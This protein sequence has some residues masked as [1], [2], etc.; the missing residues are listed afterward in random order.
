M[1]NS[2]RPHGLQP[3]RLLCPWGF[4][5]QD[6]QSE[7]RFP[8]PG[9]SP[10]PQGSN[11]GIPHCGQILYSLSH[12][13]RP[14][15]IVETPHLETDSPPP[16]SRFSRVRLCAT[17]RTA[18]Y[19]ASLSMGFSRQ[20][21]WSGL[22]FPSPETDSS[23][24]QCPCFPSPP[25]IPRPAPRGSSPLPSPHLPPVTATS[26]TAPQSTC[27]VQGAHVPLT[28]MHHAPPP[29]TPHHPQPQVKTELAHLISAACKR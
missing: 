9:E 19:Q 11:P 8:S 14:V 1:C 24:S 12:Q 23:P 15:S 5:R 3:S 27:F 10:Q 26:V 2:L 22:P 6:Y 4:S 20:E 17:P 18:A 25:A 28:L 13:G 29:S 21:H 7:L 16:P